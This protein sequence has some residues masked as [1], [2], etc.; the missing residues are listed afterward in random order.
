MPQDKKGNGEA[1]QE[2]MIPSKADE[3]AP[4]AI[5]SP[6]PDSEIIPWRSWTKTLFIIGYC[7]QF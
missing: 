1:K 5:H 2:D 6:H 4:G 3:K 7:P